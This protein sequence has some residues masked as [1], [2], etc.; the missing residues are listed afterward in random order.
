MTNT[1]AIIATDIDLTPEVARQMDAYDL[2]ATL[3]NATCFWQR[4]TRNED[5]ELGGEGSR[6]LRILNIV[7]DELHR[8]LGT[9]DE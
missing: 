8:R 3:F 6:Q 2:M 9:F 7:Q 5:G 1:D 4:A